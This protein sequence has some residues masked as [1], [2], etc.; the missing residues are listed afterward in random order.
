MP[1]IKLNLT[2]NRGL[3][4]DSRKGEAIMKLRKMKLRKIF[5][6]LTIAL[7]LVGVPQATGAQSDSNPKGALEGAWNSVLIAD[8][9]GF[10]E[11]QRYTFSAGRSANEGSLVFTNEVDAVPPC[12]TDHGL[13]VRTG[14]R[15]FTLTHGAFCV[16]LSNG[17]PAFR[18]KFKEVITLNARDDQFAGRGVFE[19]SD[20]GG[21]LLFSAT[22]TVRG[23]RMQVEGLASVSGLDAESGFDVSDS[24]HQTRNS[25]KTET[26]A[27]QMWMKK[28]R[29]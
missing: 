28:L 12:G 11:M 21:A 16:D 25:T 9:G 23:T 19:V 22:Y 6:A 13:W 15:Q 14:S 8:E 4:R 17:A 27:W 7:A 2:R 5:A 18:I 3:S 26:S 20:P 10:Q 24:E 1:I 29:Q